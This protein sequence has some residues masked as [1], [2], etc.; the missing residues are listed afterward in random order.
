MSIA[1]STGPVPL[2]FGVDPTRRE[3]Y[4][5]RQA[6]YQ[7]IGE[8]I[9]RLL[10]AQPASR[11]LK[12]LDVGVYN[13]V[14]MRYIEQQTG[15]ER[16]EFHGV[17]VRLEPTLYRPSKWAS[18]QQGNLLE[19]LPSLPDN[20]FDVVLCEQV[21]EHLPTVDVALSTLT[22]VLKPG[23]TLIVGVPIFL[24]GLHLVRKH[25]VPRWDRLVG[26]KKIRGH[27]QA[28]SRQS[29][30]AELRQH[31]NVELQEVRGFRVISGG[32]FRPLENCRWWWR[33]GREV[34]RLAPGICTEIQVVAVKR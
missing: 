12:F 23:G 7:A 28:F 17:D 9:G 32:P 30:L 5:L 14:S 21:L 27:L 2:A 19:G 3:R 18:V 33:F 24:S 29:F 22:R 15:A 8:E 6:R 10:A 31:C 26:T 25:L 16:V 13:G 1:I 20:Q 11:P 4:S 34:G